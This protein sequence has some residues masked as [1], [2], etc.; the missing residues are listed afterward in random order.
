MKT[1]LVLA[2]CAMAALAMPAPVESETVVASVEPAE[3]EVESEAVVAPPESPQ[4]T[5]A[6]S[7]TE[8]VNLKSRMGGV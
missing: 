4:A 8:I 3:V 1:R 6:A 2:W 5:V 7:R